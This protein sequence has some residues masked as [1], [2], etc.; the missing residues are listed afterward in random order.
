MKRETLDRFVDVA[1]VVLISVAAVLTALC[2]YQA[3]RWEGE[4]SRLFNL[5]NANRLMSSEVADQIFV[6]NSINV[7]LFLSYIEAS[8]SGHTDIANFIRRRFP[9]SLARAVDAWL[10]TDPLH[11]PKAPSSPFVMRQYTQDLQNIQQRD[12]G[13]ADADFAAAL[14]AHANADGF[15]LLTVIFAMVSFLAGISTKMAFPRHAIIVGMGILALLYGI[16]R[17]FFLPVL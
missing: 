13:V 15:T 14:R 6:R 9:A 10:A 5:A 2:G 16:T 12:V 3:S 1:S 7:N 17:L 11:N 8:Q 4:Q